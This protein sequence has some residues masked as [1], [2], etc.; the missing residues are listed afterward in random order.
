MKVCIFTGTRAEYG[1]LY[2]LLNDMK[3]DSFFDL[4]LI[5]S[6]THL[7]PEFGET[8]K[9]IE[10]DG[11][12][13]DEKVEILLSSDT[14]IG[15]TKS[16]GLGVIGFAEALAR[17]KPELVVVLGDRFEA[18]AMAQA[19]LIMRIPI[20]HLHGGEVTE[21]AYDD[22]IRHA[23][24]KLSYLHGTSTEDYKKRVIQ[25]GEE[26]DRVKNV[27]AIGLDHLMR[28][29]LMS[30]DELSKS[31]GFKITK[32]YFVLTFHPVTLDTNSSEKSLKEILDALDEFKDH[33][34]IITHPNADDGGRSIIPLIENYA[35]KRSSEVKSFISLGQLKYL[36]AIKNAAAVIGNS[37]SG[38]IE[39]P[40]F[41]VPTVNIGKRQL[42]RLSSKS[43]IHVDNGTKNI[44]KAI[45]KAI[46]RD[47]K[48]PG[49]KIINPYGN[50]DTSQKVIEMIKKAKYKKSKKFYDSK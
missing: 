25:M 26:P 34:V 31:L 42:G 46:N 48:M 27:G 21:G 12:F 49:E 37:S 16:I 50:G 4:Q 15:V 28:S 43:V 30:L 19:A 29:K 5:V 47:Y 23:I 44:T 14:P 9:Q 24:T 39:A 36:S 32:P 18:L 8:F 17:L 10:K 2:W 11:F 7:S 35:N 3:N 41:D 1:L 6:G 40:S 20:F 22:S 45:K 33:Q 13:I 38:I